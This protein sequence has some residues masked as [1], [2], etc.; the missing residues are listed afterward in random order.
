LTG[1]LV[2]RVRRGQTTR[3][4]SRRL[5]A[6]CAVAALAL[7]VRGPAAW[8]GAW[9][10]DSSFGRQGVA[11]LPVRE[12]GI[13]SLY[14]PGPADQGSLL[15]PGPQGSVFVGGYADRRRGAFLLVRMSAGGSLV[16]GFGSGG[17]TVVPAIYST[18]QHPPRMLALAGGGLLIVGLDRVGR[19]TLVRL[20]ASGRADR[21]FAHDGVARLTLPDTHGHA[22]VAAATVESDGDILAACYRREVQ[23]PVNEPRISPGLGEGPLELVRVMPSGALDTSYGKGGVLEAS[24]QHGP[25]VAAG[26]TITPEGSIL[27]AYEQAPP[28]TTGAR[29]VPGVEEL[30]PAGVDA[31]GFGSEGVASLPFVP[32]LEGVSSLIFGALLALPDGSVEVSFG[33]EGELFRFTPSGIL[34]PT[35]GTAGHAR[36]GSAA[37]ALAVAP[38]GETFAVDTRGKLTLAGTL[39]SG[40][41]DPALGGGRGERFAADVSGRRPSE[42]RQV[43]QLL[44]GEGGVSILVGE[45]LVRISG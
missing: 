14:P 6:T 9:H 43:V 41:P 25:G 11:G 36:A 1:R 15:A 42:E 5:A 16:K 45:E 12:E 32:H 13:D 7:M 35:F 40:A 24:G 44:A 28:S 22:I 33:G 19:L 2:S 21:S 18:P 3:A 23:Q 38:D 39:A 34:D 26:V 30:S 8:A 31:S 4:L 20:S 29:E 17:V 37:A 10:L 27:I